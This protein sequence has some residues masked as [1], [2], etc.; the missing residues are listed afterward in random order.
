ALVGMFYGK[1]KYATSEGNKTAEGSLTFFALSSLSTLAPLLVMNVSIERAVLISLLLGCLVALFEAI[2]WQGLD[3]LFIPLSAY[4]MLLTGLTMPIANLGQQLAVA[5]VL[6]ISAIVWRRRT[7]LDDSAAAGAGLFCYLSWAIGGW[8][9]CLAPLTV[10][11]VHRL[12]LP[13]K[14]RR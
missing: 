14:Y 3:N 2:A 11:C 13:A 7:T 5:C 1:H 10:L 12:I 8:A 4:A 9:W 6:L